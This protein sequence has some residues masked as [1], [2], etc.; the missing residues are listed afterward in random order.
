MGLGF[1]CAF[2]VFSSLQ[3][4]RTS[5]R[6]TQ[7]S[8]DVVQ[9]DCKA[10]S[11]YFFSLK[12]DWYFFSY[13]YLYF[14]ILSFSV[15]LVVIPTVHK[16]KCSSDVPQISLHKWLECFVVFEKYVSWP[17]EK[18][19]LLIDWDKSTAASDGIWQVESMSVTTKIGYLITHK[20][21][22]YITC[23]G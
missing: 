12:S 2:Q 22:T 18:N 11:K 19:N 4:F 3:D 1:S 21:L 13:T 20:E 6:L 8:N 10:F 7:L 15:F 23:L 16:S 9:W 17:L 14:L 5:S